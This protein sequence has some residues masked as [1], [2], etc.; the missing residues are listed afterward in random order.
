[1]KGMVRNQYIFHHLVCALAYM[2][3]MRIKEKTTKHKIIVLIFLKT[4]SP[5]LV[6]NKIYGV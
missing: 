4:S 5:N 3:F 6:L 2:Q 1:M